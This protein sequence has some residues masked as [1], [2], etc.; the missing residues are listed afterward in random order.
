MFESLGFVKLTKA[1][2]WRI[3]KTAWEESFTE[4][5]IQSGFR[6]T[7]IFPLNPELV[8]GPLR[9]RAIKTEVIV[10]NPPTPM[11]SKALRRFEKEFKRNPTA[12]Q[13][14]QACR[15]IFK[16]E[17]RN[18]VTQ[19]VN[20]G[21]KKA[22]GY[23]KTR[24]SRG[25]RLNLLGEEAKGTQLWDAKNIQLA[26]ERLA[27]KE[28]EEEAEA[29]RKEEEKAQKAKER[30]DLAIQKALRAH[31]RKLAADSKKQ[32]REEAKAA[33]E[34]ARQLRLELS[35]TQKGPK[36]QPSKGRRTEPSQKVVIAVADEVVETRP[37]LVSRSGRVIKE[38]TRM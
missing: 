31:E 37:V 29:K 33:R 20:N 32:A 17:A 13:V 5:N 38:K 2:F 12:H 35:A 22:L 30:E 16:L 9:P 27:T 7:G 8:I 28:A 36:K 25:K 4:V 14:D 19:H 24:K 21:L 10:Q 23:E 11:T 34:A 26:R 6:K 1:D 3:F 18:A 15:I